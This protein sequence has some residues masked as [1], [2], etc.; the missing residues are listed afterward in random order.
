[1]QHAKLICLVGLLAVADGFADVPTSHALSDARVLGTKQQP[2]QAEQDFLRGVQLAHG[3]GVEQDYAQAAKFYLSA[4]E[5]GHIAAQYNLAYL[6]E[7]G[8]G[9]PHDFKQAAAWYRKAALQGD[10]EAQNNL[11]V[12]Y[13]T[14]RGV[15]QRDS[16][17][18]H[19]YRLAAEQTDPEGMSNLGMMYLQGRGMKRDLIEAFKWIRQA[20]E[21]GYAVAQ[22]NLGLM[23]A[24]GQAVGRDNVWAYVWLD[25]AADQ[26]T[27]CTQLRD[28]VAKEMT[29]EEIQRARTRAGNKRAQISERANGTK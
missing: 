3:E 13:A 17:A 26:L 12:L 16:D 4:A 27:S 8:L 1:M 21:N 18:V 7:H 28:E 22:N 15:P 11:G 20:A 5:K 2:S 24:N 29:A 25:I 10:A 14:G 9:V 6:Y 23:Y 19:W